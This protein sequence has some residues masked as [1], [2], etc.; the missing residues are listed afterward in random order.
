MD[1]GGK[2]KYDDYKAFDYL[3]AGFDYKVFDLVK[4]PRIEPYY[5]PLDKTE[6]ERFQ[7]LVERST[8]IDLHE[9]PVLWPEDMRDVPELHGLGRHFTAY[10]A[11]STS[12]LD[13]VFDNLMD[14]MSYVTSFSGWKWND[15]IHDIGIRLSDIAHQILITHC[16]TVKD[17][18]DAKENG[19]IALVLALESATP[20]ENELDRIDVLYGLGVRSMGICYSESNMLGG[21]MGEAYKDSGLTDFGYDAVKR[22]NKLGLL[23][24]VGHTNDRTAIEAV[25]ASSYPIY[26]SHSGPAAIAIGHT[27]GDEMLQAMAEKG[28]VLG[29][30]GAGQGL[31]TEKYPIGSIESYMECVEYCIDLMGI[32]HVGCGP[33]T[34]YGAH[35]ELY[36]VWFPRKK[37]HYTREGRAQG[38]SWSVPEGDVDPGY[39]K[40]LEN[41]SEYVNIM[42]W[43][44][45][46]GYGDGEIQKVIGSNAMN[47]LES[48]WV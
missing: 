28:G 34:L 14:G 18:N 37:G 39:V 32:D 6:E 40:G 1:M 35:Q 13:C 12:H 36:K 42:R 43:M 22:M 4:H 26:N 16:R 31:R 15:M 48:V 2:K 44:I 46:H 29:V 25:E 41:P 5:V 30:G 3:E 10:K 47:L 24:D 38:R 33:D 7:G 19:K 9:H 11:L 8:L 27:N 21:G 17:I 45:K 23:I 20:I